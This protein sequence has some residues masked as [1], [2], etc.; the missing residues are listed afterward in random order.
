MVGGPL[1]G[2][3]FARLTEA[4]HRALTQSKKEKDEW[5]CSAPNGTV[6]ANNACTAIILTALDVETRAVLRHL[7][8]IHEQTV[9]GGTVFHVGQFGRWVVAVA[10]CGEGNANAAATA[11]RGIAHFGPQVALLVG[12]AGGVKDVTLGDAVVASKVYGYERGKDLGDGFKPRP[13]AK[14]TAY[15]LEQRAR[16]VRLKNGWTRRLDSD[17]HHSNP[18]IYIGAIAAGEKV[19]AS[20]AGEIA[21]FAREHYGDTLAIEMEGQGFLAGVHI[22][23]PVLG[24]VIRGISDLLDGKADAEKTGSQVRA[25]KC[26]N[27]C[28]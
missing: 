20:S 21:K 19:V 27:F 25:G 8:G 5:H 13:I 2:I 1:I 16:A 9:R 3:Q 6:A 10:E 4:G 15:V 22:N 17:L 12:V 14:I 11:E 18:Q 7:A 28:V 26:P 24:G 23:A